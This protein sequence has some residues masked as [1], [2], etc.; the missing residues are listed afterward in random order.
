MTYHVAK[1]HAPTTSEQSTVCL[2]CEKEF[3]SYYLL[4]QHRSKELGAKQLKPNDTVAVLNKIV[5]EERE[6]EYKFKEELSACQHFL[7]HTEMKNGRHRLF[8]FQTSKLETNIINE[9]LQ[10]V[11]NKLDS[12]AKI[13]TALGF[14]L[15]NVNTRAYRYYYANEKNTL[16]EKSH[17]LCTKADLNTIEEKVLKIEIVEQ[18]NQER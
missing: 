6:D 5:E 16:F 3:R 9:K 8:S 10:E 1:K 7:V 18:C 12:A 14:V 4:Q 2:S 17:L 15:C 11:F 13:K